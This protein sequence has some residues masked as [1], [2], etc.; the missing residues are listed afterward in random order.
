MRYLRRGHGRR[1]GRQLGAVA[2][3]LYV[4]WIVGCAGHLEL[5]PS[6]YSVREDVVTAGSLTMTL[7]LVTPVTPPPRPVLVV[8]ASGDG[9]L[10]GVSM[11]VFQHLADQGYYVAGFSSSQALGRVKD[12][13]L[14]VT[15]QVAV[16]SVA[17][18]FSQAKRRLNLPAD[19]PVI[20]TGM[21]RGA[22]LVVGAAGAP[23]LRQD[24]IGG[25]AM[26]LTRETDYLDMADGTKLPEGIQ[27]D[28][29]GRVLTYPAIARLGT[30]PL[31]I[32][33]STNDGYIKSA[34]SRVLLGPDTLTR[35][36]YEVESRNHSFG[37]GRDELMRDLDDAMQWIVG[38][39]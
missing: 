37:G 20:M 19:A 3:I 22:N 9:G 28:E 25:I 13:H 27:L 8:F 6:T 34:D 39:R 24:I 21:S 15:R 17:S 30:T 5:R 29:H 7:H 4:L 14:L 33:Q 38:S 35:R 10:R 26:A 32:I 2:A 23:A 16:E 18:L 1:C 31:A 11:A 12:A 36:L